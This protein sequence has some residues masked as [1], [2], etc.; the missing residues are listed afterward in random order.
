MKDRIYEL[1]QKAVEFS[2]IQDEKE[3]FVRGLWLHGEL[4]KL[5]DQGVPP[6]L[7]VEFMA[8]VKILL[9][10]V[11]PTPIEDEEK[12]DSGLWLPGLD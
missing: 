3:R 4:V 1:Q 10:K 11:M 2:Q 12:S 5:S 9:E 8:C 7:E 6:F